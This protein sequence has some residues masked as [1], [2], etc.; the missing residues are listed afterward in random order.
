[1]EPTDKALALARHHLELGQAQRALQR[2]DDG[3]DGLVE[4]VDFWELRATALLELEEYAA[5]RD[6]AEAGLRIESESLVLLDVLGLAE[7]EL[8]NLEAAER[9]LLAALRLEPEDTLL[10]CHYAQL[11]AR[12]GQLP[13]AERVLNEAER[14]DADDHDVV[15]TRMFLAY[16]RGDDKEAER[17]GRRLLEE[18][19]EDRAGHGMI[20]AV[21]S[22][23]GSFR[24]ASR[25]FD[26]AARYDLTD[27]H[28]VRLARIGRVEAHPLYWPLWPFQ[29]F[30]PAKTWIAAVA[31]F[32]LLTALELYAAL[33]V[34]WV[35]WTVLCI[36]SWVAPPLLRRWLGGGVA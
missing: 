11:L 31:V 10:L 28:V 23:R 6:A 21:A 9:S 2:L 25:H 32:G 14:L 5:A 20:G 30:G 26:L 8:G 15:R 35:T 12:A 27:E 4:E 1:M 34:A 18:D 17:H 29:R 33:V 24:R 16:L 22:E 7:A 13:K 3:G 36:Y 19:P